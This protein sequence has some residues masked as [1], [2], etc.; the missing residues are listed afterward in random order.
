MITTGVAGREP[1]KTADGL[2]EYQAGATAAL[3]ALG[4]VFAWRRYGQPQEIDLST[5][6]VA[7]ASADR[8]LTL[9]L[10]Y[11]YTGWSATR[12]ERLSMVVPS[13]FYPCKDGYACLVV[14]PTSRWPRY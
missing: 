8:R 9:L 11:A 4:A 13:G 10:G 12:P 7:A 1:L 5:Y 3:A 6:E 14:S 2:M